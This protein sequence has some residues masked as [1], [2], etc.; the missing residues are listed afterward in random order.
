MKI[1]PFL[2]ILFGSFVTISLVFYLVNLTENS[3]WLA[4]F[5]SSTALLFSA[6]RNPSSQPRA[7]VL[8]H[9]ICAL[10][11]IAYYHLFGESWWIY[12]LSLATGLL[13]MLL[14]RTFHPPAAANTVIMVHAHASF[15]VLLSTILLGT[16][17]LILATAILTRVMRSRTP[18]PN[19]W[20]APS[21][22]AR[23]WG[24]KH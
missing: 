2:V 21:P 14:S 20:L 3:I 10:V 7:L 6:S 16:F 12:G 19:N 1:K 8:G 22:R 9:L 17:C 13:L 24:L 4:T 23:D 15:F 5:A 11:G 18:Y